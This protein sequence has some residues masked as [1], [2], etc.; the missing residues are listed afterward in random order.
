MLDN[1]KKADNGGQSENI[2]DIY[3][4]R[5]KTVRGTLVMRETNEEI[6]QL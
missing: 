2:S 4:I 6:E 3:M 1:L 5:E